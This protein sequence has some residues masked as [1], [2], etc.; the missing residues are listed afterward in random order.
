MKNFD[1][2]LYN[3]LHNGESTAEWLAMCKRCHEEYLLCK[4]HLTDRFL[5][6]YE[7]GNFHDAVIENISSSFDS[8]GRLTVNIALRNS[9]FSDVVLCYYDVKAFRVQKAEDSDDNYLK[10]SCLYDEF[11]RAEI[12]TEN[13]V[14]EFFTLEDTFFYIEFSKLDMRRRA[15][16]GLLGLK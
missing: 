1:Y 11:Y 7:N 12:E 5:Q 4:S 8:K 13:I 15:K 2:A 14:H 6:W 3:S 10:E 16:I 9:A